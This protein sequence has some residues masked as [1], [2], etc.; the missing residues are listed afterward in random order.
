MRRRLLSLLLS[1]CICMGCMAGFCF[2]VFADD[3]ENIAL[4]KPVSASSQWDAIGA[5]ERIVNGVTNDYWARGQIM[6]EGVAATGGSQWIMIDL[7]E[8][9][10]ISSINIWLRTMDTGSGKNVRM[11]LSNTPDFKEFKSVTAFDANGKTP[12]GTD[13][14]FGAANIISC[15]EKSAYRYVRLVNTAS[16]FFVLAE[17]EIFGEKAGAG[18]AIAAYHDAKGTEYEGPVAFVQNLGLMEGV[19]ED[20]FGLYQYI[21]R[22]QAVATIVRAFADTVNPEYGEELPFED[23]SEGHPLY[24]QI[25]TA[26]KLGYV[27][28]G[29]NGQFEPDAYVSGNELAIMLLRALGYGERLEAEKS[30]AAAAVRIGRSLKIYKDSDMIRRGDFVKVLYRAM[31]APMYEADR[32]SEDGIK[33]TEGKSIL[34]ERYEL[35]LYEDIVFENNITTLLKD[36]KKK[37]KSAYVGNMRYADPDGLLDDYIGRKV[38]I[39]VYDSSPNEIAFAWASDDN[40][41]IVIKADEIVSTLSELE[42]GTVTAEDKEFRRESYEISD[43]AYYVYNDVAY[44][45]YTAEKMLIRSG[46]IRLIDNNNDDVY[47]VVLINEYTVYEVESASV[48][49]DM[50]YLKG[51]YDTTEKSYKIDTDNLV[52]YN[53]E[54]KK[55]AAGSVSKGS[56][57]AFYESPYQDHYRIELFSNAQTGTLTEYGSDSV[58]VGENIYSLASGV[59]VPTSVAIGDSVAIYVNDD[60]EAVYIKK[61]TQAETKAWTIGF[62]SSWTKEGALDS[63]LQLKVFTEEGVF[64]IF[65]VADKVILDGVRISNGAL[66]AMLKEGRDTL[67][68]GERY[69]AQNFW[70]YQLNDQGEISQMDTLNYNMDKETADSFQQGGV[71]PE[72]SRYTSAGSAFYQYNEFVVS[73]TNDVPSFT[74]PTVNGKYVS[75]Q[76]YDRY[77]K[78]GKL[79]SIVSDKES[80]ITEKIYYYMPDEYGFPAL[81]SKTKDFAAGDYDVCKSDQAPYML[82]KKAAKGSNEAG[83]DCILVTGLNLATGKEISVTLE[84]SAMMLELGKAYQDDKKWFEYGNKV[85]MDLVLKDENYGN[86]FVKVD[87]IARGDVLRYEEVEKNEY[88]VERA[89]AY[90]PSALPDMQKT[91][92]FDSQGGYTGFQF[93]QNRFQF[94]SVSDLNQ[95]IFDLEVTYAVKAADGSVTT[96]QNHEKYPASLVNNISV[97]VPHERG[98]A[99]EKGSTLYA[100]AGGKSRILLYTSAGAPVLGIIYNYD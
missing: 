33:Y 75:S 96:V 12:D 78:V 62:C 34:S 42:G 22:A 76:E 13:V 2:G 46:D 30:P 15:K 25:F 16:M 74:I 66:T 53:A 59:T 97:Y 80:A 60:G 45:D 11:D 9:F 85:S 58:V 43:R 48:S 21:T 3:G 86:Y 35:S 27:R 88:V 26:Y 38:V 90:N 68:S 17:V 61:A 57:I 39:G 32:I 37:D 44:P 72:Y 20:E 36:S 65:S 18:T 89:F 56:V 71:I 23:V 31:L 5:P 1:I 41:E 77:Y 7:E 92:W 24:K 52:V 63:N 14:K 67:A 73:A 69:I 87:K 54:G 95:G 19:S 93:C 49:G 94:A 100:Y 10:V 83:D 50:F 28:G 4:G 40:A 6:L 91:S 51:K 70:R 99:K 47:E 29:G 79:T 55:K 64:K 8:A 84:S 82:V 81:F 98:I